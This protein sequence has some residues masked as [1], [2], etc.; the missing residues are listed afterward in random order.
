MNAVPLPVPRGH[1][2]GLQRPRDPGRMREDAGYDRLNGSVRQCQQPPD[3]YN[4]LTVI[5]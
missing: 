2:E 5:G 1:Y 3:D 4:Y